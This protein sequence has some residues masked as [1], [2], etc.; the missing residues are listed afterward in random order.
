MA[1]F[2][3]NCGGKLNDEARV[4]GYC[5]TPFPTAAENNT[6][7]IAVKNIGSGK[8]AHYL[9]A[10]AIFLVI[11]AVVVVAVKV[12]IAY[13]GYNGLI[14]KTMKAYEKYDIEEIV[15]SSSDIYFYGTGSNLS[16]S[17]F[18][19]AVGDDIDYFEEKVGHNY[20]MSYEIDEI[21]TMSERRFSELIDNVEYLFS[22][23]YDSSS[24][25]K[26]VV[27]EITVTA[28]QKNKTAYR[29]VKLTMIK[30]NGVWK[31]LYME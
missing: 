27:A 16:A 17:Y 10:A 8:A 9:K 18:E 3:G 23:Y 13:T 6:D 26:A 11:A 2:C 31:I 4:C 22:E 21:Y 25:E 14:K 1:K 5:G 29:E 7:T 28:E 24:I 30:E 20:D 15:N 12:V 19:D